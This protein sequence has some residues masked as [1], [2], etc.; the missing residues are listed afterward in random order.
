MELITHD[1][2]RIV[3]LSNFAKRDGGA[4]LP[5]V[6]QKVLQKY[7]FV[8]FPNVDDLQKESQTFGMGKFQEFQIDEFKVYGD[9]II[10]SGKCN[11]KILDAFVTDLFGWLKTDYGV[12]EVLIQKPEKYFESGL[13]VR[14]KG[15]ITSIL[16]PPKRV[17]SLIERAMTDAT[18]AEYQPTTMYFEADSAGLKTRRRPNR[19]TF[20]RR[21]GLPFSANVFYSQAPMKSDDHL[22]LLEGLEGLAD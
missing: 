11:T 10:V 1:L 9:G 19:F 6:A 8:K 13:L 18:Q 17:T 16:S 4:F 15:D 20:E 5:E 2:S 7:S 3:Y 14:P 22:A 21:I 12:E